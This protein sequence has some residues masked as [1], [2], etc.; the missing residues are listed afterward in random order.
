M[1]ESGELCAVTF[2][3]GQML[4]LSVGNLDTPALVHSIHAF[5]AEP[6]SQHYKKC[7]YCHTARD[8]IQTL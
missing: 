5:I 7:L 2:G 8:C 1:M 3:L 4:Q 6:T